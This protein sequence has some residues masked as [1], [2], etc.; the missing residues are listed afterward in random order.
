MDVVYGEGR[1]FQFF[2]FPVDAQHGRFARAQV[3]VGCALLDAEGEQ[4]SDIHDEPP[5]SA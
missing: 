5:L 2:E 3:A 4:L 1:V